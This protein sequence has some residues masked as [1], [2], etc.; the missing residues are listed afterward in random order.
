MLKSISAKI[1]SLFVSVTTLVVLISGIVFI[2]FFSENNFTQ[3]K[4]LMTSC[5]ENIARL[6]SD[7]AGKTLQVKELQTDYT[8]YAGNLFGSTLWVAD[9]NEYFMAASTGTWPVK[10]SQLSESGAAA[11][12]MSMGGKIIITNDLSDSFEEEMVSV[13]VPVYRSGSSNVIGSVVLTA[14]MKNVDSL[15]LTSK[16]LLAGAVIFSVLVS[17][18]IGTAFSIRFTRPLNEMRSAAS[19]MS[20]GNYDVRIK[21]E[22]KSELSDLAY[23][24]NHLASTTKSSV[25]KLKN[26]TLKLNNIIDN[27]SDGLAAFDTNM[28]LIKYNTALLKMCEEDYF[29][30]PEIREEALKVMQDGAKRT[31]V[32]EEKDILKFTITPIRSND[33][34]EGVVII[35]SDISQSERL[36][37][38]RRE[39]V[40]NVSH[41]FRTPL[42]I[43][44][45]SVEA[46]VLSLIHI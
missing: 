23:S 18:L 8:L 26:E 11:I 20:M 35:V 3:N 16:L 44:R 34:V 12:R 7:E 27:V 31:V 5:A 24:L 42:T 43:I 10:L 46:L 4:K 45:G 41:E 2:Y 15:T 13:I 6:V 17:V 22:D 39:F 25:S 14:P 37:K 28:R 1:I 30:K 40:A 29:Q 9:Q 32:I 21:P 38:L 19:Q 33:T 36:E